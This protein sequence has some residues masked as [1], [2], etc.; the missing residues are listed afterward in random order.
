M[1]NHSWGLFCFRV[2]VWFCAAQD[3]MQGQKMLGCFWAL[4]DVVCVLQ[5]VPCP[6]GLQQT[7]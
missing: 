4:E 1:G 6:L 3:P 5:R 7:H 2:I